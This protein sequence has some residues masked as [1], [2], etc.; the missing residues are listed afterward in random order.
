M[1]TS[2]QAQIQCPFFVNERNK[3]LCCEG[4]IDS[5]CMTTSFPNTEAKIS[6]IETHCFHMDG[7]ECHMAKN[8]FYKYKKL[9]EE[10]IKRKAM[11]NALNKLSCVKY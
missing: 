11:N 6:Y 3:L 1:N 4:Y 8:L 7:G 2:I 5:T 9:E 10:E